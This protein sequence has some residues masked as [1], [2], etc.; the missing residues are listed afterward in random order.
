[1]SS[2]D[3]RSGVRD[4]LAAYALDAVDDVERRAVERLVA[5]DPSAAEELA[6]LREVTAMLGV[7]V[8]SPPPDALRTAV[9]AGVATTPQVAGRAT[10]SMPSASAR[11]RDRSATGSRRAPSRLTRVTVGIA[12]AVAVAVAVPSVVAWR[13]HDRAVQAEAR[14]Q[15]IGAVLAEPG[16]QVLRGDVVG[17]GEAV[18]VL[19]AERAVLLADGLAS[20]PE[21]RTYQLWAM[22]DGVPVPAGLL[23]VSDGRVEALA[24]EYRSGDGLAVSVEPAGGSAQPTT[25]PVVVLLPS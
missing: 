19:G 14:A 6:S 2:D 18:A 15:L 11:A 20:V 22:R 8:S 12:A 17:G 9:L 24:A 23:D 21:G 13:E 25:D 4:L 3:E 5:S 16:A 10:P 7:A 1:M